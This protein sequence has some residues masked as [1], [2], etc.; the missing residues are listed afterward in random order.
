MECSVLGCQLVNRSLKSRDFIPVVFS[1]YV[2]TELS[3]DLLEVIG[4]LLIPCFKS[5]IPVRQVILLPLR[6]FVGIRKGC[7]FYLK[8]RE[9]NLELVPLFVGLSDVRQVTGLRFAKLFDSIFP[10]CVSS[11]MSRLYPTASL[12]SFIM[13]SRML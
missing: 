5:S 10:V 2:E 11:M 4:S 6:G 13:N 7:M 12:S 8:L 1:L 3:F 9:A